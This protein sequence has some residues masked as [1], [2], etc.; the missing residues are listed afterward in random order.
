M[1]VQ[2][3]L[4][5]FVVG[6]LQH[7]LDSI[8]ARLHQVTRSLDAVEY[9]QDASGELTVA[10]HAHMVH[11]RNQVKTHVKAEGSHTSLDPEGDGF[12]LTTYVFDHKFTEPPRPFQ[13]AMKSGPGFEFGDYQIQDADKAVYLRMHWGPHTDTKLLDRLR[14][15]VTEGAKPLP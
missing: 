1:N 10:Y 13:A 5:I 14:R 6:S 8:R 11:H 9:A 15:A 7:P 3:L 2:S 4:L 12:V